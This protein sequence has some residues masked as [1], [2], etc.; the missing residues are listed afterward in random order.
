MAA[1]MPIDDS[2]P[3]TNPMALHFIL[4]MDPPPT[5]QPAMS[6]TF[7]SLPLELRREIYALLLPSRPHVRLW[8]TAHQL[9]SGGYS[10]LG[11]CNSLLGSPSPLLLRQTC[12]QINEEFTEYVFENVSFEI[13]VWRCVDEDFRLSVNLL[14]RENARRIKRFCHFDEDAD[15]V[16]R[17]AV[18]KKYLAEEDGYNYTL[19]DLKFKSTELGSTRVVP[20]LAPDVLNELVDSLLSTFKALRRLEIEGRVIPLTKESP[21][22]SEVPKVARTPTTVSKGIPKYTLPTPSLFGGSVGCLPVYSV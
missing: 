17:A 9:P 6:T 16:S 14:G 18:M 11:S 7:L 13:G 22:T 2:L 21:S 8:N 5:A 10:L 3:R 1:N 15:W 19:W 4:T 20:A 12:R